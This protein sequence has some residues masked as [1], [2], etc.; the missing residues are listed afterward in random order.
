MLGES[1]QVPAEQVLFNGSRSHSFGGG[2]SGGAGYCMLF[3]TSEYYSFTLFYSACLLRCWI[4]CS[5]DLLYRASWRICVSCMY[6]IIVSPPAPRSDILFSP[7]CLSGSSLLFFL[8]TLHGSSHGE[9]LCFLLTCHPPRR[10]TPELCATPEAGQH[11]PDQPY[12]P[13]LLEAQETTGAGG[14]LIKR[15][16]N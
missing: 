13:M 7:F 10:L 2:A 4:V 16:T 12:W 3:M 11:R 14:H 9:A 15:R 5:L 6:S 8:L 1:N